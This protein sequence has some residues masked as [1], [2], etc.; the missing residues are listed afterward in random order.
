M[1]RLTSWPSI[2]PRPST[3]TACWRSPVAVK[4]RKTRRVP[5]QDKTAD[6]RRVDQAS[7]H[8]Q[9]QTAPDIGRCRLLWAVADPRVLDQLLAIA[10]RP[11]QRQVQG[12]RGGPFGPAGIDRAMLARI[13]EHD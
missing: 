6:Q 9:E 2:L 12:P 1:R 10:A 3:S 8:E 4:S 7:G 5:R 13:G 11:G